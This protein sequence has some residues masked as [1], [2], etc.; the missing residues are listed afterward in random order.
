MGIGV[1]AIGQFWG[2]VLLGL[3]VLSLLGLRKIP[4]DPPYV[5]IPTFWGRRLPY[6]LREG[7]KLFAP[8]FP[9][10][11]D[12]VLILVTRRNED[13]RFT[14][15]RCKLRDS[16][17]DIPEEDTGKGDPKSGGSV[18]VNVSVTW[19]PD[20]TDDNAPD[21]LIEFL[22]SGQDGDLDKGTGVR[23]IMRDMLAEDLRHSGRTRSWE[24]MVFG[25]DRLSVLLLTKMTGARV[26]KAVRG[27]DTNEPMLDGNGKLRF[28]KEVEYIEDIEDAHPIEIEHF[29]HSTLQNGCSD[30]WDLGISLTRLNVTEVE[31]EGAL[32]ED[33]ERAAREIQQREAE[34]RD[35]D[36]ETALANDYVKSARGAGDKAFTFEEGLRLARLARGR[37]REQH[38]FVHGGGKGEPLDLGD[39]VVAATLGSQNGGQP[40]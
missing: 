5:A 32:K 26:K 23:T 13:F 3:S 22:N 12:F 33:A 29:L 31:P 24:Q 8:W 10:L 15:V 18:T 1:P 37:I 6:M 4:E 16:N 40:T 27:G 11:L 36:T 7:W 30:I 35:V 9:F 39:K 21:R 20:W 17:P 14:N 2:L 28:P 38:I 25:Q 19:R 34:Q